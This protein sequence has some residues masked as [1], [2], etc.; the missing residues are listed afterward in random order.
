MSAPSH[1]AD[2]RILEHYG[3]NPPEYVPLVA[4]RLGIHLGYAES[5]VEV[6]VE[7]GLL[8]PVSNEVVYT[9][10]EAGERVLDG[11]VTMGNAARETAN[12]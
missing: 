7:K 5:R 6:L 10:T 2:E 12:D 8:R 11:E 3:E 9:T 4:N 1:P